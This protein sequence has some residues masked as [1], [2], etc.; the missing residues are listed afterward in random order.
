MPRS[1]CRRLAAVAVPF[2]LTLAGAAHADEPTTAPVI[3][4]TD[5]PGLE[6]FDQTP[7]VTM[8]PVRIGRYGGTT[9]QRAHVF[10]PVCNPSPCSGEL[11]LGSH[12]LALSKPGRGL[13]RAETPVTIEGPSTIHGTLEDNSGWR[14]AGALTLVVSALTGATLMV[15][16]VHEENVQDCSL[17]PQYCTTETR[18]TVDGGLVIAGAITVT[19]GMIAGF[20]MGYTS[21]RAY[22]TVTPLTLGGS[23]EGRGPTAL[24][25]NGL[26]VTARF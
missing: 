1:H 13:V 12:V 11:A 16:A 22:F 6:V 19:A 20:A 14:A 10:A 18:K 4:E 5:S 2:C 25:P 23:T 17:G 3:A 21:D 26:A 9:F 15:A 8:V 24:L 7:A